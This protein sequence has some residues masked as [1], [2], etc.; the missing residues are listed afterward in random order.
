MTTWKVKYYGQRTDD[1]ST[2]RWHAVWRIEA[3][4]AEDAAAIA[5]QRGKTWRAW[6]LLDVRAAQRPKATQFGDATTARVS[7]AEATRRV[8]SAET[9]VTAS[10]QALSKAKEQWQ[11]AKEREK[12]ATQ[13]LE[14]AWQTLAAVEAHLQSLGV[15]AESPLLSARAYRVLS[16]C[17]ERNPRVLDEAA[18][19]E[20]LRGQSFDW[21]HLMRMQDLGLVTYTEIATFLQGIV[22][23]PAPPYSP[24]KDKGWTP[25]GLRLA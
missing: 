12:R 15:A 8:R 3:E 6:E 25:Q 20:A 19:V 18:L 23:T 17:A 14:S 2:R 21:D 24:Q 16:V 10:Q 4:S 22:T 13:R 1:K 11:Q 9:H 5:R 7:M